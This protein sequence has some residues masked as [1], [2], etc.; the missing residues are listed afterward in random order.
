MERVSN[1]YDLVRRWNTQ[2]IL[3]ALADSAAEKHGSLSPCVSLPDVDFIVGLLQRE[4]SKIRL[5]FMTA[6]ESNHS[7]LRISIL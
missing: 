4:A 2:A 3:M 1:D 5:P 6:P 7:T